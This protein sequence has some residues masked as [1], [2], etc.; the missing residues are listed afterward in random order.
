MV[1][2]PKKGRPKPR[3]KVVALAAAITAAPHPKTGRCTSCLE[4]HKLFPVSLQVG[5]KAIYTAKLCRMCVAVKAVKIE[6][7]TVEWARR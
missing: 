1:K 7:E 4:D 5:G 3:R 2:R 6:D